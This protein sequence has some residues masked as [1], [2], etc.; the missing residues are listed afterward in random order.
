MDKISNRLK[1]NKNLSEQ[2]AEIEVTLDKCH[3]R[4]E[5]AKIFFQSVVV[6]P[7]SMGSLDPQH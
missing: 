4:T 3:V 5:K 2:V 6:D 1:E 7:D